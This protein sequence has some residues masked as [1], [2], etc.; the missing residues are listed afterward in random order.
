MALAA[1]WSTAPFMQG[2]AHFDTEDEPRRL[3]LGVDIWGD[4]GT[5]VYRRWQALYTALPITITLA[6]MGPPLS[7]SIIWM[8]L[9]I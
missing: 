9:L 2:S 8:G 5:P 6:I 4:A 7:C 3:H 1:T